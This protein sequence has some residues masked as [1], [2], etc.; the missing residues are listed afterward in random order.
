MRRFPPSAALWFWLPSVFGL[1]VQFA[2]ATEIPSQ[3]LE[4]FEKQVRPLLAEHCYECHSV[5]AK[6]LKGGLRLD[7]RAAV[8]QGGDS[9]EAIVPK[10]PEKSNLIQAIRWQTSEM[11]PTG[12]L[13]DEQI[14]VLVKWVELGAPWPEEANQPA[15]SAAKTYDFKKLRV[16]HWAWRS[17][18]RPAVPEAADAA[19]T[20]NAIDHFVLARLDAAGLQPSPPAEPAVLIRRVSLDLTGLPPTPEEIEQFQNACDHDRDAAI[21]ALVDRLLESPHYGERWGRHWLDVAR[22]SDGFGG[23]LDSAALPNAWRYRDWVIA[24]LNSDMPYDDFVRYQIAGDLL[25]QENHAVAT[26]FLALGP[27]YI[28]DGGDPEA[29]AQAKSETLD[30]R[31]DT[32]TRGLMAM[33]VACARCHDHRFDPYPQSDYYSLAGVFNNTSGREFPLAKPDDVR[34]YDDAM[35]PVKELDRKISKLKEEI[36]ADGRRPNDEESAR[37]RAWEKERDGF[38]KAVPPKYPFAHTIADSGTGDM[39]IAIR[40]NLLRPGPIAPRRFLKIIA[41]DDPP[42][43]TRGSGRLDLAEAIVDPKNPLTPRVIVNRVWQQHFGYGLVRTPSNFGAL[44]EK[45]SHPELLDWLAAKLTERG[46]NDFAWSLKR[47]HRLIVTSATY[48]QASVPNEAAMNVDGDNRLLWRMN[49]RRL[50]VEAWRDSLLSATGELDTMTGGPSVDDIGS[51]RRRTLYASVSRN[52]DK[53]SSDTFLRLFDFPVPRATNE[54]RTT[55]IVPQ[56]SLFMMNSKFMVKRAKAL[57]DRLAKEANADAARIERAYRL[58]YGRAPTAEERDLGLEFLA[59]GA[60][61][62]SEISPW[63]QYAQVLLSASELMFLN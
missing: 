25:D 54:G 58:L 43:F 57:I 53:F 62:G 46:K 4:F 31:V 37:I 60:Q 50:D 29:I 20:K 21:A 44:G 47:L 2:G 18:E 63:E 10:E 23:F 61:P 14:A 26:G 45:P 35:K 55:S 28:S 56:Q 49:P 8:I 39:N 27:T 24:A 41:G 33:T 5:K 9:G 36:R 32:I 13:R 48:Q 7:S 17:V 1:I 30:D 38:K 11:P 51:S 16:E 52:G 12:K 40:G 59:Q 42:P 6:A 22:Y 3:H 19:W 34:R 15:P